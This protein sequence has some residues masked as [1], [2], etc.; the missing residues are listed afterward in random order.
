MGRARQALVVLVVEV[1]TKEVGQMTK[2]ALD[3]FEADVR[4]GTRVN[5]YVSRDTL[6]ELLNYVRRLEVNSSE[7]LLT[8]QSRLRSKVREMCLILWPKGE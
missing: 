1:G 5:F 4:R 7:T 8:E 6:M 3:Q 2:Q